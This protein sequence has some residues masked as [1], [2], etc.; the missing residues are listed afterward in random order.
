MISG[1]HDAIECQL[2]FGVNLRGT[3]VQSNGKSINPIYYA[4][5]IQVL[6]TC[7]AK[8]LRR[9]RKR[10]FWWIL[11]TTYYSEIMIKDRWNLVFVVSV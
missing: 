8:K 4:L 11:L 5:Y 2:T 10:S 1:N 9:N 7:V 3:C 6:C